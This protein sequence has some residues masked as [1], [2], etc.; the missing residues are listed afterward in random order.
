MI[1]LDETEMRERIAKRLAALD[2]SPIEA[3]TKGGLGRDFIRDYLAGRKKSFGQKSSAKLAK[4]LD[5]TVSQLLGQRSVRDHSENISESIGVDEIDVR[6]GAGYGGGFGQEEA[7]VDEGG[8]RI[9]RDAVRATWGIPI[10]FLRDELRVRP[11]RVH[12]LPVKGDSMTDA[13][14]DGDRVII[15][16]DDTEVSQ[17]GIFALLDDNAAVIIKQVEVVRGEG[18]RSI[19]CT[20][21]NPN[22]KPFDLRLDDP[23]RIIGRVACKITR[24]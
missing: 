18:P 17:G 3:A 4:G 16:L 23:V 10:P 14:F 19:R 8:H 21:R 9:S 11:E 24:L 20:S 13:L 22:Y 6:G 1:D 7:T 2:R 5:W 12:I 15:D